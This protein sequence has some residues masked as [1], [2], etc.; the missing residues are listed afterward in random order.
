MTAERSPEGH[1]ARPRDGCSCTLVGVLAVLAFVALAAVFVYF[2]AAWRAPESY[3]VCLS[4]VKNISL[5]FQMYL[6]DHGDIFPPTAGWCDRLDEYVRN[7]DVF[8]CPQGEGLVGEYAYN[9]S[10]AGVSLADIADPAETVVVFE[11]DWGW[12]AAG[13]PELLPDV[14]RHFRDGTGGDNY[15]FADGHA[16]WLKRKQNPD[17][18]YAKEPEAEVRWEV[19]E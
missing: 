12:N 6:A 3:D 9:D 10:L 15:G 11:S 19:E 7:R 4:N 5:A 1:A 13:G 17:G 8:R 14:P 18:T 2:K 16:E